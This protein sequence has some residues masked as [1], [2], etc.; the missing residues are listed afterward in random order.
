MNIIDLTNIEE[1]ENDYIEFLKFKNQ[2]IIKDEKE[3][4]ISH[5]PDLE[6]NISIN[7]ELCKFKTLKNKLK[8]F[9]LGR[10]LNNGVSGGFSGDIT[11]PCLPAAIIKFLQENNIVSFIDGICDIGCGSARIGVAIKAFFPY[12]MFIGLENNLEVARIA[13]ENLSKIDDNS[14]IIFGDASNILYKNY[15]NPNQMNIIDNI[16]IVYSFN[17]A[18]IGMDTAI[19]LMLLKKNTKILMVTSFF[20]SILFYNIEIYNQLKD[21]IGNYILYTH[22]RLSGEQK[23][24]K[25]KIYKIT[26][27]IRKKLINNFEIVKTNEPLLISKGIHFKIERRN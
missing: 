4:K 2:Y 1:Q 5:I 21:I 13:L 24:F 27:D 19:F 26:E 20:K 11:N 3:M 6:K 9:H 17:D 18:N 23:K 25:L 12:N 7:Y 10:R 15:I 14:S 16:N 22:L 8:L